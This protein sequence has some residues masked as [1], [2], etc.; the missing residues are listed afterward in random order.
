MDA[1]MNGDE[2]GEECDSS[3]H[4]RETTCQ[5]EFISILQRLVLSSF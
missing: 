3:L 4:E 2:A 1:M 5:V